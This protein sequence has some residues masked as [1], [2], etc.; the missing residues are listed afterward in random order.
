MY[1]VIFMPINTFM[2]YH[3]AITLKEETI[4][5]GVGNKSVT[6]QLLFSTEL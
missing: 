5:F 4:T 1:V 2:G 6:E 3:K